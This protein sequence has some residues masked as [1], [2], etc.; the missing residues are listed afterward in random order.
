MGNVTVGPG[1][2]AAGR[3]AAGVKE[4][5]LGDQDK[6]A[7]W[8]AALPDGALAGGNLVEGGSKVDG[9]GVVAGLGHPGNRAVEG[10]IELKDAG[11]ITIAL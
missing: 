8:V 2:V 1:G 4:A 10:P 5:L 11:A 9:T 3:G 7:L 6:G